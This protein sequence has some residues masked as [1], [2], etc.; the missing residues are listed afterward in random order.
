MD[1]TPYYDELCELKNQ[2]E[3]FDFENISKE[4]LHKLWHVEC[5]PDSCISDLFQ[6]TKYKVTA[7]RKSWDLSVKNCVWEDTISELEKTNPDLVSKANSMKH[8]FVPQKEKDV[9]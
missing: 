6:V 7:K 1:E 3:L 5:I 8:I 2:K 9:I 4:Q